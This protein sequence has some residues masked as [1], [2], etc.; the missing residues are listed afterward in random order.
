MSEPTVTLPLSEAAALLSL[1]EKGAELMDDFVQS[2]EVHKLSVDQLRTLVFMIAA[3]RR[4][5]Q[6]IVS[7]LE[8]APVHHTQ[9]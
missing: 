2:D 5:I 6:T 7:L 8:P 4:G 1:A 9:H 3:A